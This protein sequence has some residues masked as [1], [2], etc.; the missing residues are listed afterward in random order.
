MPIRSLP[1][2]LIDQIAAGEVVER[3]ASVVKELVENALDAGAQ[4]IEVDV[5]GGGATLVR[6]V[7]DGAGIPADELGLAVQRHATSKIASLDDLESLTSLGFRGEA[8]PSIGSV[9]RMRVVSRTAQSEQAAQLDVDAGAVSAV[10]PAAHPRGTRV[11]VRDLFHSVPARRKFLRTE[12]TEVAHVHRL[13]ERFALGH[14]EAALLLRVSG[15]E[16]FAA[17]AAA[18]G[19]DARVAQ[20]LGPEFLASALRIDRQS[21]PVHLW[22]WLGAPTSS[23][24]QTDQQFF[25]VNGRAVRD[26]LLANA[27][28]L[29]YRD[30]LYSGRHPAYVLH[31]TL[32]PRLVDVNAHPQK[33]EVR[34]RDSRQVHDFVMREISRALAVPAGVAGMPVSALGIVSSADPGTP[35]PDGLAIRPRDAWS[36]SVPSPAGVAGVADASSSPPEVSAT[37]VSPHVGELGTAIAQLHGIYIL[38]QNQR[39]LV[40]VDAHA[41]HERVLYESLKAREGL[42]PTAAQQLLDPVVL[43]LR[44]HEAVALQAHRADFERAGFEIDLLGPGMAAVRSVPALWRGADATSFVRDVVADL[45]EDRGV[46]HLG[47]ATDRVLGNVACRAAIKANRRLTLDEMNALL[48]DM[49]RTEHASHC[50]HGR[51]TW[52]E[53]P[54]SQLDQLFLRGR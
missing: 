52:T 26:R 36:F 16:A 28:R 5:D 35:P 46:H 19:A 43:P 12:A 27:V 1:S 39:G 37:S 20:V 29:G 54:M 38:A 14:P 51:P 15:R 21:G 17:A 32:E 13:M 8:L 33:L 30:V 47:G 48:R 42:G 45:I 53:L 25:F 7:D 6:V 49:E 4:R 50:N 44:A 31:L 22:G 34:F 11:E 2:A 10:R 9:S 23:R 40:L 3:P 18:A 24:S 41:A